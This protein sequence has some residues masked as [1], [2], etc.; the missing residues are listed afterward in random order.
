[1]K[2]VIAL[3]GSRAGNRSH[4]KLLCEKL[5]NSL[6]IAF[7]EEITSEIITADNWDIRPC[8]SCGA[9]F[10]K[11]NCPLD[12]QDQMEVIKEKLLGSDII[13]FASPVYAGNVSG[14]MKVLID[15]LSLW[16]HI[17][18]LIGKVG[19]PLC[20]ASNNHADRVI[21]YLSDMLEDMGAAVPASISA[22][23][24][25]GEVMLKD[26][27]K[28]MQYLTERSESVYQWYSHKPAYSKVQEI[29]YK[30]Q[31]KRYRKH[32]E[33]RRLYPE[34]STDMNEARLWYEQGYLQCETIYDA[35]SVKEVKNILI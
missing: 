28:L 19:I 29:R 17:M 7:T 35:L 12:K 1:M 10:R 14:D 11:G 21:D 5:I 15:R 3:V 20:T 6:G 30:L 25:S 2:K 31:N 16:L 8:Y 24:H 27:N 26:E 4:T 23:Q 13:I 22:Y 32:N 34:L 18:P 33:F 9:C